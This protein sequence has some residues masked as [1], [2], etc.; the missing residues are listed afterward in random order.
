M[1]Q[2]KTKKTEVLILGGGAAGMMAALK[3]AQ[4]G[5]Q[6]MLITDG[7]YASTAILGFNALV[8]PQ[9]SA[10]I[11]F[12]D[13]YKGGFYVNDPELIYTFVAGTRDAVKDLEQV[14]LVFDKR[15]DGSYHLLQPLGC[16]VPRLVHA[17]NKTGAISMELMRGELE[18]LG[19]ELWE[20]T[21]A[22]GIST[23]GNRAYGAYVYR[24]QTG[25]AWK[26]QAKAVVITTGGGH[27]LK[28]STYPASQTGDGYAM[29]YRAGAALRDMEF[30]QHEPC[31]AVWPK[32]LGISTT[33]LA[34]GGKLTNSL[35]ERFVLK[36]HPSEGAA[37]KD[38][39]AKIIALEIKEGRATPHGGVWLDLTDLPEEEIRVNHPLYDQRFRTV[40]VDLC[41]EKVEV[42]PAAHSIMGGLS[43]NSQCATTVE[44]LFAA[45]EAMGGLHGANRLGGNA[46]AEVYVFG[47]VAGTSSARYAKAADWAETTDTLDW[48][49]DDALP[50]T[51]VHENVITTV[52][53]VLSGAMGPIREEATLLQAMEQL[54]ALEKELPCNR[55]MCW[56]D[57]IGCYK[58]ENLLTVGKIML[59]AALQRK[60]SRGVHTRLDYPQRDDENWKKSILIQRPGVQ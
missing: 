58:A 44:G 55:A 45:G 12:Q 46:G 4:A 7:G 15:E 38:E 28:G 36:T 18:H 56:A 37:S 3:A 59:N 24:K 19:V 16:S 47:S 14:G 57:R 49:I 51:G 41:K 43:V 13:I 50:A 39:L 33:L 35:G 22:C 6:V 26:I 21:V 34:K 2:W 32:P 48:N 10:D 17:D 9:D 52:R 31:R 11:F 8:S 42:G 20:H 30:I 23:H 60:E 25:E 54:N 40:G 29:G 53:A 27:M 5:V 1:V